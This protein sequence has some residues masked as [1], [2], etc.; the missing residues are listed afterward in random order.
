MGSGV[1]GCGGSVLLAESSELDAGGGDSIAG[2]GVVKAG[3]AT[4]GAGVDILP[5]PGEPASLFE[6]SEHGIEGAASQAGEA[7]DLEPVSG[8]VGVFEE[9][10]EDPGHLWGDIEVLHAPSVCH[11]HRVVHISVRTRACVGQKYAC[12]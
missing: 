7:H 5:A 8:Q 3:W 4:F 11:L 2:D 1:G 10:L 6:A 9:D 12:P